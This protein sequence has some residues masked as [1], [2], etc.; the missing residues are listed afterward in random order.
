M[1][2][3]LL[4][5]N[6]LNI[7]FTNKGTTTNVVKNVNFTMNQEILGI[8]GESG[9]GKSLIARSILGLLPN[10]AIMR[11][12]KLMYKGHDLQ[13]TKTISSIRGKEISMILQDPLYSFNPLF[14]IGYQI[15][16]IL[17]HHLSLKSKNAKVVALQ[18][19]EDVQI[20]D[21]DLV[22]KLYP[23]ELS[24]GMAQR[25]M[26]AMMLAP[27]PKLL[28][29]DEPTS[30]L[31][32]PIEKGIINIFLNFV[33]QKGMGLLFI[34]HD[35]KL[36]SEFCDRV[37]IIYRGQI[38]EQCD[39]KNLFKAQHPYTQGLLQ[40]SPSRTS[41]VDYLPTITHDPNWLID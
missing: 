30:S 26:I 21:P 5:I 10:Q 22:L 33:K 15:I 13:N 32:K 29:A 7:S 11:A 35:L 41:P 37:I 14:T 23:H 39:A 34:S 1:I 12:D 38:V 6:N 2:K 16:E 18:L 8:V 25:A 24:G 27:E 36:V 40:C 4:D 19:L 17:K 9:S 3:H 28:I 31:D 20:S